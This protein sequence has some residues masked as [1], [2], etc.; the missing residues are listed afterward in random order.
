MQSSAVHIGFG[1]L[2]DTV[3]IKKNLENWNSKCKHKAT[4]KPIVMIFECVTTTQIWASLT[5]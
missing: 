4:E 2:K 3:T 1:M 5:I